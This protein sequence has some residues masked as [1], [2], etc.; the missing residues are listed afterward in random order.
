M[1]S[2]KAPKLGAFFIASFH[3]SKKKACSQIHIKPALVHNPLCKTPVDNPAR[4]LS[5]QAG[6]RHHAAAI[7]EP[8]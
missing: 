7:G 2:L 8:T 5:K 6:L 3:V 1:D 4:R